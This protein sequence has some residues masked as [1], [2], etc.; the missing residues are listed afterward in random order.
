MKQ[1]VFV[2]FS[3]LVASAAHGRELEFQIKIDGNAASVQNLAA[4]EY[5]LI[6]EAR[7]TG[8]ELYP[9]SG[10]HGGVLAFDFDVALTGGELVDVITPPPGTWGTVFPGGMDQND[11]GALSPDRS[12]A[13]DVAGRFLPA[14][15]FGKE[16]AVGSNVFT[17]VL[18]GKFSYS[19]QANG[20]LAIV[21][22]AERNRVA[23]FNSSNLSINAVA[24]T[25]LVLDSTSI[26]VPEPAFGVGGLLAAAFVSRIRRQRPRR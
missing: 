11:F 22:T 6:V 18:S 12:T 14:K 1:I 2:I 26:N 25:T 9:S 8:N 15:W 19:G 21:S 24:P 3:A 16:L 23:T 13:T 7:V 5:F 4:G 10:Y 17:P 20:Q